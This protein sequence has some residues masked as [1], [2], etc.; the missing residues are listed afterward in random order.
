MARVSTTKNSAATGDARSSQSP[1]F[2]NWHAAFAAETSPPF[3]NADYA[4]L[5]RSKVCGT[6]CGFTTVRACGSRFEI[7]H[8]DFATSSNQSSQAEVE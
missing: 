1:A 7:R 4:W 3:G 5:Q 6:K 8:S 2:A